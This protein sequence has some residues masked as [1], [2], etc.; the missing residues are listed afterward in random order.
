[1]KSLYLVI[2]CNLTNI[3]TR[4]KEGRNTNLK[5]MLGILEKIQA[6]SEQTEKL[7][8]DTDSKIII[9]DPQNSML[10]SIHRVLSPFPPLGR[11]GWVI[12]WCQL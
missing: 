4:Q 3:P 11:H 7:D 10:G 6:G 12:L 5:F 1:M 2:I 8:P 9:P